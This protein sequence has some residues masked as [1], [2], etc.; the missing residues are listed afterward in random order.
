MREIITVEQDLVELPP[1]SW[2]REQVASGVHAGFENS[3]VPCGGIGRKPSFLPVP[4]FVRECITVEEDLPET[5]G[6]WSREE[7]TTG[8]HAGFCD[9]VQGAVGRHA[10]FEVDVYFDTVIEAE[11]RTGDEEEGSGTLPTPAGWKIH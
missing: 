8:F 3:T 9:L 2:A 4:G 6:K 7:I 10:C 5:A 11:A 1:A